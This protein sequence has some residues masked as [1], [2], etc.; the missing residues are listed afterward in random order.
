MARSTPAAQE[1]VPLKEI[2]DDIAI[3]KDGSMRAILMVSSINFAL[4]SQDEQ[5]AILAQFQSFLNTLDF[6]LQIYVQSRRLNIQPYLEL[7]RTR[8]PAQD[9]DLMRVQLREYIDFVENLTN[10]VEIMTK[11]FFVVIAYTPSSINFSSGIGGIGNV[12]KAKS[13]S[14]ADAASLARFE[15]DRTQI[16]QRIAVVTQGLNRIGVRTVTLGTNEIIE[17][18]YH[19]FNPGEHNKALPV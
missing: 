7:L 1:F 16:E 2:R 8:E 19:L 9:N 10:E 13:T 18:F 4:K 14:E 17:L 12:F 11:S 6:S 15:E 3:L 5:H